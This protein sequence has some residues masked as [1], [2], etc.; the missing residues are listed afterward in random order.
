M[1]ERSDSGELKGSEDGREG[2]G[3]GGGGGED[4]DEGRWRSE[5]GETMEMRVECG[6]AHSCSAVEVYAW[7]IRAINHSQ[8]LYV[9]RI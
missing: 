5:D 9:Y 1:D 3:G 7:C 2:G 6:R 4:E 8:L